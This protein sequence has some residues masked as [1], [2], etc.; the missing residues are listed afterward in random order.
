MMYYTYITYIIQ[1]LYIFIQKYTSYN[2][3][4]SRPG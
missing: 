3:L 2:P 4:P 1:Y